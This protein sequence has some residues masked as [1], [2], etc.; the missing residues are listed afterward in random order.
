MPRFLSKQLR[1]AGRRVSLLIFWGLASGAGKPSPPRGPSCL[2]GCWEASVSGGTNVV[3]KGQLAS[4]WRQ[5]DGALTIQLGATRRDG[6]GIILS[7]DAGL[8]Q[9]GA[10]PVQRQSCTEATTDSPKR[11]SAQVTGPSGPAGPAWVF[12]AESGTVTIKALTKQRMVGTFDFRGCEL[13]SSGS[14]VRYH[15]SGTFKAFAPGVMG[16]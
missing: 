14:T 2:A 10:F 9:S 7:R 3:F 8:T 1:V 16:S 15:V 12:F 6:E 4:F 5:D 11:F 13:I